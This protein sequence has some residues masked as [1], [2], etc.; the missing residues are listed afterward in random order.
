M[1]GVNEAGQHVDMRYCVANV[2]SALDSVSQICDTG[3]EVIFRKTGGLIRHDSGVEI[4]F[5]REN[6]TYVRKVWVPK[7]PFHRQKA[8]S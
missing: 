4:P 8:S 6:N 7:A 5:Q 3:A 1:G 2:Q